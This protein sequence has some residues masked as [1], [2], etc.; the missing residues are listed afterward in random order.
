MK[1]KGRLSKKQDLP[2]AERVRIEAG[3]CMDCKSAKT[4]VYKT[5]GVVRYCVC[6]ECGNTWSKSGPLANPLIDLANEA[7]D[8]LANA[9]VVKTEDA[10]EVVIMDVKA[11]TD[12]A[13]RF[14]AVLP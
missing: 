9:E 5:Q 12:L 14:V 4:R 3:N 11:A 8:L 10:K 7:V 1:L 13:N 2:R 6:D